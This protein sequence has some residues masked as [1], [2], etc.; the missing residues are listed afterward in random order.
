MGWGGGGGACRK[1]KGLPTDSPA[2]DKAVLAMLQPDPPWALKT[3][4]VKVEKHA[5]QKFHAGA[6]KAL[7]PPSI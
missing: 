7:R 5:D 4:K 3:T 1:L 6:F 2:C